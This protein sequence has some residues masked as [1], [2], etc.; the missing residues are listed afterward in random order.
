M[1]VEWDDGSELGRSKQGDAYAAN[2][3]ADGKLVDQARFTPISED[4]KTAYDDDGSWNHSERRTES[5][6]QLSEEELEAL[7]KLLV[8]TIEVTIAAAPHVHRW[9]KRTFTPAVRSGW[10]SA[11]ATVLRLSKR[12]RKDATSEPDGL[13]IPVEVHEPNPSG[14]IAVSPKVNS[15]IMTLNEAQQ[16]ILSA[17]LA[18]AYSNEQLRIV[19]GARIVDGDLQQLLSAM[20]ALSAEQASDVV[21]QMLETNPSLVTDDG[22]AEMVKVLVDGGLVDE[23]YLPPEPNHAGRHRA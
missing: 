23:K 19:A 2:A 1:W 9:Y 20:Q 22:A 15:P 10:S 7:L 18:A 6:H 14:A 21:G 3:Y 11:K 16:R 12:R 5:K 13:V 8:F 4:E 17:L